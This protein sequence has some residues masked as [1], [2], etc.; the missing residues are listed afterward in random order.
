MPRR[1]TRPSTGCRRCGWGSPPPPPGDASPAVA[2]APG[3]PSAGQ[4]P[5]V[6]A[7]EEDPEC[8][9]PVAPK[10]P[11][12]TGVEVAAPEVAAPP[13]PVRTKPGAWVPIPPNM[14]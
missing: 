3:A 9:A 11:R 12:V 8:V 10:P 1:P 4:L 13:G 2:P 14:P 5:E 6:A 7:D